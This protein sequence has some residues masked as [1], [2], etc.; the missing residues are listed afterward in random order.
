MSAQIIA[1]TDLAFADGASAYRGGTG[2]AANPYRADETLRTE[3][4]RGWLSAE[5]RQIQTGIFG[6]LRM[7]EDALRKGP[8]R[9]GDT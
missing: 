4:R 2:L 7:M 1:Q 6:A 9:Y 3:W 8:K 5:S